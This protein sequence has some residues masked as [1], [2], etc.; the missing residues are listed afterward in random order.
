MI[1]QLRMRN[2]TVCDVEITTQ[3]E[4]DHSHIELRASVFVAGYSLVLI[5]YIDEVTKLISDFEEVEELGGWLWESYFS[6]KQNIYNIENYNNVANHVKI[7]L[8]KLAN[9]YDLY[10]VED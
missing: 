5:K 6:G 9:E 4:E 2:K 1:F 7:L 3:D 8:K 10:Y